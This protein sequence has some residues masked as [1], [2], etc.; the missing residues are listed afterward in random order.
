[1]RRLKLVV[2]A[3]LVLL[4]LSACS[5]AIPLGSLLEDDDVTGAI[6]AKAAPR[7]ANPQDD[8]LAIANAPPARAALAQALESGDAAGGGWRDPRAGIAGRFAAEDAVGQDSCRD[9]LAEFQTSA[10]L[11]ALSG[12]ACR[13]A[14]GEWAVMKLGPRG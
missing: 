12:V 6:P 7:R 13:S 5:I 14:Q 11:R 9:I 1:M 4:A 3:P 10:G 2:L 8:F